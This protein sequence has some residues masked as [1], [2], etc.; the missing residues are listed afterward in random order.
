MLID[1]FHD[2]VCP[3][4]RIG[5]KHLFD[6]LAQWEEEAVNIRWHPF[7]LDNTIPSEG[8][9]FRSFMQKRKGISSAQLQQIFDYTRQAGEVAGVQLNFDKIRLAVNTQLAHKL[10]ALAPVKIRN[11]IV[12]AIY[13]AY[14]ENGLN[15]GDIEVLVAIGKNHQMDENNLRLKLTANHAVDAVMAESTFARLNGIHSVPFFIFNNQVRIDGSQ[16]VNV[17][18]EALNRAKF[19]EVLTKQ[20]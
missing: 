5:K 18:L 15:I 6:A 13:Q 7:L 8:Y 14:F 17:F 2:T 20:W 19:I 1:I 16:S 12:E 11:D 4:C 10:I 9:E 3:W